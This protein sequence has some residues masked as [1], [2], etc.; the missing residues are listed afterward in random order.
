MN[1][2]IP[3]IIHMTWKTKDIL[4]HQSNFIQNGVRNL[5]KLNP[6]WNLTI[7]DDDE[8][9]DYIKSQLD[10][11]DY[12]LFDN[13]CIVEKTD[14]W[15]LIKMYLEGGLYSDLDRL[16]NI[17]LNNILDEQ[18]KCVLP[19]CLDLDFA[20][21]FMMSAP[22]NPIFMTTIKLLLE[23]RKEGH[24]NIYFLGPQTYM[25]GITK[26][27]MG[28]IVNSNPGKEK[29][30]KIRK[31]ISQMP[32]LKTYRETGPGDLITNRSDIT[33][34]EYEKQKRAFYAEFGIKHWTGDW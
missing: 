28:E 24:N 30:D 14:I 22:G 27:L 1:T 32:F 12:Q 26:M 17:P 8:I 23:R 6:D 9:V 31:V 15:R 2:I 7:Y 25:H 20:H 4:N 16:H 21:T 33:E 5:I 10:I 29:F 13:C 18:T 11:T 3:K 19:T 34:E